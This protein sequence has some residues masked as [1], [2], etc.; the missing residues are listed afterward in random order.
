MKSAH[1]PLKCGEPLSPVTS[2]A[3]PQAAEPAHR[4]VP[5]L[6]WGVWLIWMRGRPEWA[7]SA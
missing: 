1:A 2:L 7:I 3:Q 6:G 5:G 4:D